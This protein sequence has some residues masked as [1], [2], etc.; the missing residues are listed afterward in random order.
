[1]KLFYLYTKLIIIFSVVTF[2]SINHSPAKQ[3]YHNNLIQEKEVRLSNLRQ[4]TFSGENAEAYF[5][6]NG[7]RLFFQSHD[8]DSLCD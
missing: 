4:L 3:K 1:M 6:N 2:F 7:D 5:S 8:G